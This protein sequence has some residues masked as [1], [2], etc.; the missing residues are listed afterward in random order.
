[1]LGPQ[2]PP[3]PVSGSRAP[4]RTGPVTLARST[5]GMAMAARP[6]P[7]PCNSVRR[8]GLAWLSV[9]ASSL[10]IV[11]VELVSVD[12]VLAQKEPADLGILRHLAG[13][14]LAGVPAIDEDVGAVRDP[15]GVEGVLLDHGD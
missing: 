11:S 5:P 10:P 15:Q 9:I 14:P 2:T 1:M 3:A 4:S 12:R 6:A 7:A 8:D 13:I